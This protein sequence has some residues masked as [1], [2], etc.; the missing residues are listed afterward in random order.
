VGIISAIEG[1][2]EI[3]PGNHGFPIVIECFLLLYFELETVTKLL[4]Q[5]AFIRKIA[6]SL[7]HSFRCVG[8][9]DW[10]GFIVAEICFAEL[11][12]KLWESTNSLEG[13]AEKHER[14]RSEWTGD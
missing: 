10:I 12:A 2:M 9:G 8:G 5:S 7:S 14:H 4:A 3:F 11:L 1:S 13:V 6:G